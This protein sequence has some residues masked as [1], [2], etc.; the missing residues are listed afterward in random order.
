[1]ISRFVDR[2]WTRYP[3]EKRVAVAL[4]QDNIPSWKA[5]EAAGFRRAWEGDLAS[6]DP[7]DR[8]PSFIYLAQR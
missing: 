1:M 8:G 5:L 7:S 2:C 6:P 3:G 4:Q